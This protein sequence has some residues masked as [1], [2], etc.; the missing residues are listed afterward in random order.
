MSWLPGGEG[1]SRARAWLGAGLDDGPLDV[2]RV[3]VGER[4]GQQAACQAGMC[5]IE[6]LQFI[7]GSRYC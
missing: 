6:R 4:A 2:V 5:T 3:V 7:F 1:E